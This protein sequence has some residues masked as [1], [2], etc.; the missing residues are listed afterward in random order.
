MMNTSAAAFPMERRWFMTTLARGQNFDREEFLFLVDKIVALGY[1]G[2]GLY[3]EGSFEFES[4]PGVIREGVMTKDD[5]LFL[6]E[7]CKRRGIFLFPLTNVVGHMEQ[8]FHQERFSDLVMHDTKF[9]QINFYDERAE[10]FAMQI[11]HEFTAAF[12]TG[13]IHI[14]GDETTLTDENKM[15]Y[16]RFLAKIAKNLLDE[17]IQPA[18]WD[19]MLWMDHSL[20]APFDRR[21]MIFDWSYYGHRPESIDFFKS[22]GFEKII[23]C[24]CENSWEGFINHQRVSTWLK[25][26]HDLPVKPYEV[27]AFLSDAMERNVRNGLLTN[28]SSGLGKNFYANFVPIA[29]AALYMNGKIKNAEPADELIEQTLF[30]RI[31]PYSEITHI[32]QEEVQ[33]EIQKRDL[34]VVWYSTMRGMLFNP[35]A[36]S[37]MLTRLQTLPSE[38]LADIPASLDKIDG[39]L[40][41]WHAEGKFEE[42]CRAAMENVLSLIR[43]ALSVTDALLG[44][45]DYAE[46]ARGQY[47]EPCKAAKL[48]DSVVCRF[49]AAAAEVRRAAVVNSALGKE[50]MQ[51]YADDEKIARVAEVLDTFALEINKYRQT[52]ARVVLPRFDLLL[53]AVIEGRV[54]AMS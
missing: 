39:L 38:F 53:G 40:A 42:R 29:R 20:V 5:A 23:V 19:D 24:P 51:A 21:I 52:M 3:I 11:V 44:Y 48:L 33:G 12:P 45:R 9:G 37:V 43:A 7:E 32:L 50:T 18:I 1:N 46:A 22:E 35:A 41:S 26:R 16:A 2:L 30:G 25:A 4:I 49:I 6:T 8:F 10:A 36:L 54:Y 28:W 17:G 15:D 13:F 47:E 31:T 14:G 34:H 27:E